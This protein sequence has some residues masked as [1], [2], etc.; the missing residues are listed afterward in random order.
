V[1]G[2]REGIK[3]IDSIEAEVK[4]RPSKERSDD[5]VTPFLATKTSRDESDSRSKATAK[6]LYRL[7]AQRTI[8]HSSLILT[9]FVIRFAHR[10]LSSMLGLC[11][12]V[13]LRSKGAI[14]IRRQTNS[15]Q[16]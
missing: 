13:Y 14:F 6:A 16:S 1:S 9:L 2:T 3:W 11:I 4:V 5:L 7:L 10:R 8:F 15:L 12:A